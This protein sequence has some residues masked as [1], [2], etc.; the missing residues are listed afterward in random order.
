[1][2][3]ESQIIHKIAFKLAL[4]TLIA[5]PGDARPV[6]AGHSIVTLLQATGK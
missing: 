4:L 6:A 5:A 3:S 1:M 2:V